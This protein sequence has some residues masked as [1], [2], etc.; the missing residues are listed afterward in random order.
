MPLSISV[1]N[2]LFCLNF[3]LIKDSAAIHQ[4]ARTNS[5]EVASVM[6]YGTS[7][8]DSRGMANEWRDGNLNYLVS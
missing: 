7:G 3:F 2:T 4:A 5:S 1:S 6:E 8:G